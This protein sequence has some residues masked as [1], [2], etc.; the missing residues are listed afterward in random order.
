MKKNNHIKIIVGKGFQ[1]LNLWGWIFWVDGTVSWLPI[2]LWSVLLKKTQFF[3]DWFLD[4]CLLNHLVAR[5]GLS[6][7]SPLDCCFSH[8]QMFFSIGHRH[9]TIDYYILFEGVVPFCSNSISLCCMIDI[10]HMCISFITP[11]SC[12]ESLALGTVL[13]FNEFTL[14]TTECARCF[15]KHTSHFI[16]QEINF[17]ILSHVWYVYPECFS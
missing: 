10:S 17:K 4:S 12:K 13:L 2:V 7:Y 15:E 16:R 9:R 1:S 14:M 3:G 8:G 6:R 11:N 5:G